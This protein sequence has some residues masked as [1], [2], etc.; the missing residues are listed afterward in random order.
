[1][2]LGATLAAPAFST[3][4]AQGTDWPTRPVVLVVP[5]AAGG[6]GDTLARLLADALRPRL[7]QPVVVENRTGVGGLLGAEYVAKSPV[8]ANRFLLA[9]VH[10]AIFPAVQARMPYDSLGDFMPV[11]DISSAYNALIINP[12]LPVRSVAELVAYAKANPG[13]LNFATAGRGTLHHVTASLFIRLAGID[14]AAVHYRGSAPAMNDLVAGNVQA[15]FETMPSAAGQIR[16][17]QVRALAVT[18]PE[19]VGLLP[20]VPTMSEA[21]YPDVIADTWYGI[22]AV[23]GTPPA[24]LERMNAAIATSL[25]T[26]EMRAAWERNGVTGGGKSV[27]AFT[28]M[29]EGEVARWKELAARAGVEPE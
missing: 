25:A 28:R 15:M 13:R 23:R 22:F 29:W 10:H 1:M 7:P 8:E 18:A 9:A 11:A 21:G 27:A 14:A 16:G 19:R 17:G 5:T 4:R 6:S 26:P 24:V 20:D 12:S 3:A 2:I